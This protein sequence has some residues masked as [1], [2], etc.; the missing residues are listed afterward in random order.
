MK[1]F[2]VVKFTQISKQYTIKKWH[3]VQAISLQHNE[4]HYHYK[5]SLP[6]TYCL[7]IY[8]L[9]LQMG[10]NTMKS[11]K[12]PWEPGLNVR[13]IA[14]CSNSF[15]IDFI[16]T[17]IKIVYSTVHHNGLFIS[18]NKWNLPIFLRQTPR[19]SRHSVFRSPQKG[20]SDYLPP[21]LPPHSYGFMDVVTLDVSSHWPFCCCWFIK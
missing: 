2:I 16:A 15:L 19:S 20:Q 8:H 21:P 12:K 5:N 17:K 9:T 18:G 14:W 10:I 13:I 4:Q 11:F 1:S 3:T 6:S 7:S